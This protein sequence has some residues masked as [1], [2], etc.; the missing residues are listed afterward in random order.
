[1]YPWYVYLG[2]LSLFAGVLKVVADT[3]TRVVEEIEA[4]EEADAVTSITRQSN[5]IF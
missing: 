2:G 3:A 4:E 1:V 5:D